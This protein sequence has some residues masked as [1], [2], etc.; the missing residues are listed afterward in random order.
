M[1]IVYTAAT[2]SPQ[3]TYLERRRGNT[4]RE[5]QKVKKKVERDLLFFSLLLLKFFLVTPLPPSPS[6]KKIL[7]G[8]MV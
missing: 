5:I 1:F 4:S 2:P 7:E 8:A 6:S 3:V